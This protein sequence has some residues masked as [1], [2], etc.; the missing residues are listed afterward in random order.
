MAIGPSAEF[1]ALR[2][3]VRVPFASLI[4]Y[5]VTVERNAAQILIY[6]GRSFRCVVAC[7]YLLRVSGEDVAIVCCSFALRVQI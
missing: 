3:F 1:K 7:E 2:C 5:R 4:L 6:S